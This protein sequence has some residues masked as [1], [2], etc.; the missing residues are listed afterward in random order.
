MPIRVMKIL[1][2]L[3]SCFVAA[4]AP[5]LVVTDYQ[6]KMLDSKIHTSNCLSLKTVEYGVEGIVLKSRVSNGPGGKLWLYV[7]FA[8]PAGIT[9]ELLSPTITVNNSSAS[10]DLQVPIL[11][12][13][14]SDT[15]FPTIDSI[16]NPKLGSL[17]PMQG[18][19]LRVRDHTYPRGY[20]INVPMAE[21]PVGDLRI[22]LP[23]MQ[24][25]ERTVKIPTVTFKRMH[26][27]EFMA[28]LNC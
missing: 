22:D 1:C 12:M 13:F 9:A 5:F 24:I 7:H 11:G 8:V 23:D 10:G 6:P 15:P 14:T 20:W 27:V 25:N 4:C 3:L 18:E 17:R 26:H 2:G 19:D 16:K 21:V 28:P